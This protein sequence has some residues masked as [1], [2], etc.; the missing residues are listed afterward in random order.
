M[1]DSLTRHGRAAFDA[2]RAA[3][4]FEEGSEFPI[5]FEALTAEDTNQLAT[6]ASKHYVVL[7]SK[8]QCVCLCVN[9][10][11]LCARYHAFMMCV[12]HVTTIN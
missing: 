11:L 3:R 2:L 1:L 7:K 6:A 12:S 4:Y 10:Y 5:A 8:L 9:T